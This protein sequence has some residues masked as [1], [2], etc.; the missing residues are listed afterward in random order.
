MSGEVALPHLNA[1]NAAPF[2]FPVKVVVGILR[3]PMNQNSPETTFDDRLLAVLR[4]PLTHSELR[5][6][7]DWLIAQVG[8]L[9]YPVREGIPVMLIEEARLPTGIKSLDELKARLAKA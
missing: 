1:M 5:H 9:A 3:Q 6:E 7:G 2:P 4:C 8:G